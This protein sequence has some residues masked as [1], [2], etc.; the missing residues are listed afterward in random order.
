MDGGNIDRHTVVVAVTGIAWYGGRAGEEI[1]RG[2]GVGSY[3]GNIIP[4][5]AIE[6]EEVG[7]GPWF[8]CLF[9]DRNVEVDTQK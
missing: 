5:V 9:T 3:D 2:G 8:G 6:V 7:C 4:S 1:S